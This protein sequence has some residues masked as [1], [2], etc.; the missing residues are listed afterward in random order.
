MAETSASGLSQQW[1]VAIAAAAVAG[2]GVALYYM[3]KS[4]SEGDS[5]PS[6]AGAAGPAVINTKISAAAATAAVA[7]AK[8]AA[9]ASTTPKPAGAAGGTSL[10]IKDKGNKSFKAKEFQSALRLYSEAI[11]VNDGGDKVLSVLF[12]NRAAAHVMLKG[13]AQAIDDCSTALGLGPDADIK[14]KAFKRRADAYFHAKRYRD[15]LHDYMV[16]RAMMTS[17]DQK[18]VGQKEDKRIDN[19]LRKVSK[20]EISKRAAAAAAAPADRSLPALNIL[21]PFFYGFSRHAN[22][23]EAASVESITAE[24]ASASGL[25]A[26]ILKCRRARA[27][28]AAENYAGVFDELV[29][30]CE[31]LAGAEDDET[32][33]HY[34][35]ALT[36]KGTFFHLRGQLKEAIETFN[37]ILAIDDTNVE[38]LMRRAMVYLD[39]SNP[40][41]EADY[42]R[43]AKLAPES[44]SVLY[45]RGQYLLLSNQPGAAAEDFKKSI[46]CGHTS[47]MPYMALSHALTALSHQKSAEAQQGGNGVS[48][49]GK[50]ASSVTLMQEALSAL[51]DAAAKFAGVATVYLYKGQV[52]EQ[53]DRA[54][55]AEKA[56]KMAHKLDKT[57]PMPLFHLG[58]MALRP[59]KPGGAPNLVQGV[60]LLEQAVKI[61]PQCGPALEHLGHISM[62]TKDYVKA[63]Y[64]FS[65]VLKQAK[66]H[67]MM[68]DQL[69]MIH[70]FKESASMQAQLKSEGYAIK[71]I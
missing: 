29:S 3:T 45:H 21:Q 40:A 43:A 34:T 9:A 33:L 13:Y 62:S 53:A 6:S 47:F 4:A 1:K 8:P 14:K 59:T 58:A 17:A 30:A 67:A 44:P 41:C 55:D 12:N 60:A 36:W 7:A 69:E 66:S 39:Q 50:Q 56:F 15:A 19:L 32:K 23:Q 31:L 20:G 11:A 16:C 70:I 22:P 51:D 68:P 48:K 37:Q 27:L 49:R 65:Q 46:Q 61:E 38:A 71:D 25:A 57:N 54:A 64:W 28:I 63:E 10:E 2:A 18:V 42:K 35:V 24:L 26:G 5:T 52:L